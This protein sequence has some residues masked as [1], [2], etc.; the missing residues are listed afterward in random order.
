MQA[1]TSSLIA[2]PDHGGP[3]TGADCGVVVPVAQS[4]DDV[5]EFEGLMEALENSGLEVHPKLTANSLPRSDRPGADTS[6]TQGTALPTHTN[7]HDAVW[8]DP[9]SDVN[10]PG[11]KE[12]AS[13]PLSD[14]PPAGSGLPETDAD[15]PDVVSSATTSRTLSLAYATEA[16]EPDGDAPTPTVIAAA[17]PATTITADTDAADTDV[18]TGGLKVDAAPDGAVRN[19]NANSAGFEFGAFEQDAPPPEIAQSIA[20]NDSA[21]P[22]PVSVEGAAESVIDADAEPIPPTLPPAA[23]QAAVADSNTVVLTAADQADSPAVAGADFDAT[24]EQSGTQDGS[25]DQTNL[26]ETILQGMNRQEGTSRAPVST[27]APSRIQHYVQQVAEQILVAEASGTTGR[28]V[29]IVLKDSILPDTSVVVS[30][31]GATL[32]VRFLTGSEDA[33][34]LLTSHQWSI[35]DQLT[36]NLDRPVS[37]DVSSQQQDGRSRGQRD[38]LAELEED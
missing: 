3:T 20:H 2:P 23:Q 17:P 1:R 31:D 28:E 12:F 6:T 9:D 14:V 10:L 32:V 21:P 8:A 19:P 13:I 16:P 37:V 24:G 36:S 25:A 4:L 7:S 22:A 27:P 30:R 18:P 11:R 5:A 15:T 29:H 26:G 38:V 33:R 35:Q 34:Q